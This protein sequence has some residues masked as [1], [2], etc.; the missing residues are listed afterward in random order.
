[1]SDLVEY[2]EDRFSHNEAHS[3]L[4]QN[5]VLHYLNN[6]TAM[7]NFNHQKEM[8]FVPLVI[9]LKVCRSVQSHLSLPVNVCSNFVGIITFMRRINSYWV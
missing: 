8:F 7:L 5:N 9:I 1:M 2:P 6:G 3:I 4:L